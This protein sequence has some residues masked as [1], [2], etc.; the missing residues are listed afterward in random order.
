MPQY[1]PG[2]V[3]S[4]KEAVSAGNQL[5]AEEMDLADQT[6]AKSLRQQLA[7]G[8][9]TVLPR[10]MAIDPE[11]ATKMMSAFHAMGEAQRKQT[12]AANDAVAK[13]AVWVGMEPKKGEPTDP[14]Q[15]WDSAID[16][17]V[18]FGMSN[19]AEYKGKY[20]PKTWQ[21]VIT[22]AMDIDKLLE[23]ADPSF[24]SVNPSSYTTDEQ[25]NTVPVYAHTDKQGNVREVIGK[26]PVSKDPSKKE[27][28]TDVEKAKDFLKQPK[29]VQDAV[30]R[31]KRAQADEKGANEAA[32]QDAKNF[33]KKKAGLP[34]VRASIDAQIASWDNTIKFIDKAL[35]Q[36]DSTTTGPAGRLT[37]ASGAGPKDLAENLE[38]IKANIGFEQL[39]T[40]RDNSPTGGALG[41][42]SDTENRLLQVVRGSVD[43]KQSPSQ[44]RSNLQGI[45]EQLKASKQRVTAAF[46]EDYADLLGTQQPRAQGGAQQ[47]AQQVTESLPP[48]AQ[49]PNKT[50]RDTVTGER[51]K[52]ING[53]WVKQ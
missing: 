29:D 51:F 11:G 32:V 5:A 15:R 36:I 7:G 20:S 46:Q 30:M 28:Q 53:Q 41:P 42:V 23:Y 9:Q 43:Q 38:T 12:R 3:F 26:N 13:A 52:S 8:N 31:L 4:L 50:V 45:K 1:A 17:L 47:P 34:K 14:A 24:K 48:A 44:L 16:H 33:A 49:Y 40:M 6:E 22:Q 18:S 39:Q 19:V 2:Q 21:Q 37:W 10:L 25:G 35:S 27:S